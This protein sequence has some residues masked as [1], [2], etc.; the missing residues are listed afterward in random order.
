MGRATLRYEAQGGHELSAAKREHVWLA[1]PHSDVLQQTLRDLD[2]AF[3]RFF[4]GQA[5]YPRFRRK[6]RRDAFRVQSRPNIGEVS[7]RRLSR[8]WGEVR[9]PKLGWVRF[10]WSRTPEGQIKHMTITRDA[11]GWHVSLCCV[12]DFEAPVEHHGPPVGIDR[13]VAATVAL[14]TGE[15]RSRPILTPGQAER[16]RRLERK[17]GR[18]ETARRNRANDQR[19]RSRHH[20]RTLDS[21]ARLRARDARIRKDFLH[22]L[23]TD[24]AKNHGVVV[25]ERLNVRGMTRS[26]KGTLTASGTLEPRPA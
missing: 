5:R 12:R 8:H 20:Q 2:R 21:I 26:A 14:S 23:S 17:A 15:L 7:V 22:K 13:G 4:S 6:G 18:Q 25:I 11:L 19:D 9:V 3:L 10:R 24:I 1:E 16:L